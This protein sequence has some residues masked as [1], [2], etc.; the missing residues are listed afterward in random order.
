ML[1]GNTLVVATAIDNYQTFVNSVRNYS[2]PTQAD[3][4]LEFYLDSDESFKKVQSITRKRIKDLINSRSLFIMPDPLENICLITRRNQ[5]IFKIKKKQNLGVSI[6]GVCPH[7]NREREDDQYILRPYIQSYH[8]YDSLL[9]AGNT[10]TRNVNNNKNEGLPFSTDSLKIKENKLTSRT[11]SQNITVRKQSENLKIRIATSLTRGQTRYTPSETSG[12]NAIRKVPFNVYNNKMSFKSEK[13]LAK[14]TNQESRPTKTNNISIM[15]E[16]RLAVLTKPADDPSKQSSKSPPKFKLVW[17]E[18][19]YSAC[20][21]SDVSVSSNNTTRQIKSKQNTSIGIDLKDIKK[22]FLRKS[23]KSVFKTKEK[24]VA[25]RSRL[26]SE[27]TNYP[28]SNVSSIVMCQSIDKMV[29][30]NV[31]SSDGEDIFVC[32]QIITK[33]SSS[34]NRPTS[35]RR[36]LIDPIKRRTDVDN[37]CKNLDLDFAHSFTLKQNTIESLCSRNQKS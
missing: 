18:S 37:L 20:K 23:H 22:P 26:Q 30:S 6:K 14:V 24:T 19:E 31:V 9:F 15:S 35:L 7:P 4:L 32:S 11:K 21:R 17:K 25:L 3:V 10:S 8:E 36:I 2:P 1:S 34:K 13:I 33:I 16:N 5:N 28:V 29:S 12:V 27:T